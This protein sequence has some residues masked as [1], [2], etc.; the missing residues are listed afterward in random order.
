MNK[1]PQIV[2]NSLAKQ[3]SMFNQASQSSILYDGTKSRVN[4]DDQLGSTY[5]F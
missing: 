2:S 4:F 1:E 5:T 3:A